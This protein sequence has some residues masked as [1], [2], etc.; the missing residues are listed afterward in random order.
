[1]LCP[2][3]VRLQEQYGRALR[4]C[5]RVLLLQIAELLGKPA[6]EAAKLEQMALRE[7]GAA[8]EGLSAHKRNCAICRKVRKA[9]PQV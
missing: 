9:W 2:E 8:N 1:M 6:E 5:G 7:R 3:Y 4:S